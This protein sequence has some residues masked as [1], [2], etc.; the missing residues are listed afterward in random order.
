MLHSKSFQ[1]FSFEVLQQLLHGCLFG[2]HPV[3]HLIS[4]KLRTEISLEHQPSST[5]VKH[6]F[7]S[8]IVQQL[9]H[10]IGS[11]LGR[12]ELSGRYVEKSHS[13][14]VFPKVYS[15]QKIVFLIV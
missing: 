3:V 9:V 12:E 1:I 13:T 15:S 2:K 7:R 10:I 8:K 5:L 6:F 11:T 4:H 14:H